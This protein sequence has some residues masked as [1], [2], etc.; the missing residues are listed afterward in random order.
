MQKDDSS[1][2]YGMKPFV[3]SEK[4]NKANNTNEWQR[5]GFDVRYYKNSLKT[6][7][8]ECAVRTSIFDLFS[9]TTTG[10]MIWFLVM[11]LIPKRAKSWRLIPLALAMCSSTITTQSSFHTSN[12]T[13]WLTCKIWCSCWKASTRKSI[14]ILFWKSKSFA[15]QLRAIPATCSRLPVMSRNMT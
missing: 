9:L 6:M 4:K 7:D 12:H 8:R 5:G 15:I 13:L 3:Y 1:F 10:T 2:T 11:S 14:W